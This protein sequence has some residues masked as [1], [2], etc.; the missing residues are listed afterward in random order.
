ML[1][2][3]PAA[4]PNDTVVAVPVFTTDPHGAAMFHGILNGTLGHLGERPVIDAARSP[5]HGWT[6]APQ[7]FRGALGVGGGRPVV[8]PGTR[9]DQAQGQAVAPDVIQQIFESRA[10][11]G[12]F[13]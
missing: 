5:W 6:Q 10:S 8:T 4:A 1:G 3:K 12:R 9:L 7:A 2:R 11:T 13:E